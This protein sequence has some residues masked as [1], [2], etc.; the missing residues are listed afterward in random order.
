MLYLAVPDLLPSIARPRRRVAG[1]GRSLDL[2]PTTRRRAERAARARAAAAAYEERRRVV[3]DLHDGA[4][5]RLVHTIV[6]LKLACQALEGDEGSPQMLVSEA[7]EQAQEA[8]QE[9]RELANG[10][11][12]SALTC[13][14]LAAG[15]QALVK[16]TPVPVAVDVLA[17]RLPTAVETAA[18]FVVAEALT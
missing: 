4:Q 6:V 8:H 2:L 7:L 17:G 14:G 9:L 16:R 11:S 10:I 5:A 15:V 12:P 1:R 3:R 13:G 18:Y